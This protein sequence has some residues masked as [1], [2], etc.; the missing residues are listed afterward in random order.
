[1]ALLKVSYVLVP[2]RWQQ[3]R[4]SSIPSFLSNFRQ[5]LTS[6]SFTRLAMLPLE[7]SSSTYADQ[8]SW[9]S[10][11]TCSL[12]ANV[13]HDQTV[14]SAAFCDAIRNSGKLGAVIRSYQAV[15]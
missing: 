9:T 14:N 2:S 6:L 3:I 15:A 4:A 10:G 8:K 13:Q 5:T 12:A 1:M 7:T 11:A